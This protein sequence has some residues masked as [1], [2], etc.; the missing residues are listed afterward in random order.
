MPNDAFQRIKTLLK[1][2][3]IVINLIFQSTWMFFN[4]IGLS[5]RLVNKGPTSEDYFEHS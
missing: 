4:S 1:V 3:F 2:D 5:G